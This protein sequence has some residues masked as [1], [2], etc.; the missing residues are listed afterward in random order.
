M[1]NKKATIGYSADENC[2]RDDCVG[3]IKEYEKEG[4]CSCHI[5]PPCGYCTEQTGY[6]ETCG[7]DAQEEQS[8]YEKRQLEITNK[9]YDYYEKEFEE[10]AKRRNLFYKKLRGDE[11]ITEFDYMRLSHCNSGM[12]IIGIH[13]KGF[14]LSTIMNKIRGTF[15]GRF[16]RI[17]DTSFEYIAYT[18]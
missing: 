16:K 7:W 4:Y 12:K 2:N 11:E 15:G 13:P 3:I 10:I 6:C 9:N 5:N 18:D 17:S 14:D 8:E 1:K